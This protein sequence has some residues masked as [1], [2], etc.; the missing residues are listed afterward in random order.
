MTIFVVYDFNS[1]IKR[2]F[3][4]SEGSFVSRFVGLGQVILKVAI[5]FG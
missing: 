4:S 2:I 3:I 1:I 5:V